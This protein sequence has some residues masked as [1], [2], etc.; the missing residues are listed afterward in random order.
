[1]IQKSCAVVQGNE[2]K[3]STTRSRKEQQKQLRE[4]AKGLSG[5]VLVNSQSLTRS[6]LPRPSPGPENNFETSF[7]SSYATLLLEDI[8]NFHQKTAPAAPYSVPACVTK[9]RSIVDAVA[10]LNSSTHANAIAKE[11]TRNPKAHKSKKNDKSSSVGANIVR[12]D[13]ME[14]INETFTSM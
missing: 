13:L 3:G 8:Q 11:R 10:D 6:G 9:A 14:P 7:K 4:E 12:N 5:N 2:D 1:M